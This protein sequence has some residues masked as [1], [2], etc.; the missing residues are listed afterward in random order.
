MPRDG[1][2]CHKELGL[3]IMWPGLVTASPGLVAALGP[4]PYQHKARPCFDNARPR[5]NKAVALWRIGI[6]P[7]KT[8]RGL[9]TT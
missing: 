5:Y 9:V 6:S 7:V 8:Y 4:G 3:V 2:N 1:R